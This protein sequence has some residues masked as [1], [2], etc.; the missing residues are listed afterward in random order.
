MTACLRVLLRSIQNF[1][2]DDGVATIKAFARRYTGHLVKGLQRA[3]IKFGIYLT[4]LQ[5][6]GKKGKKAKIKENIF[7]YVSRWRLSIPT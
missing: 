6:F 1:I 3:I 7:G 5:N 4:D 2:E